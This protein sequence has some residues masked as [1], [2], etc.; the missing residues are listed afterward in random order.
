MLYGDCNQQY[1]EKNCYS[2]RFD[3]WINSS[4][5]R[6]KYGNY[7][8]TA[9]EWFHHKHRPSKVAEKDTQ[10]LDG[11]MDFSTCQSNYGINEC[12]V[13]YNGKWVD[14]KQC[15]SNVDGKVQSCI[16]QKWY[17]V[18]VNPN[19]PAPRKTMDLHTCGETYGYD[20]CFTKLRE[21]WVDVEQCR[22]SLGNYLC[23]GSGWYFF[24][25]HP[26][27][28]FV[29]DRSLDLHTCINAHGEDKCFVQLRGK[30]SNLTECRALIGNYACTGGG[31]YAFQYKPEEIIGQDGTMNSATCQDLFGSDH[32]F[33]KLN[34]EWKDIM[35]C[36]AQIGQYSC[37]GG[38]WTFFQQRPYKL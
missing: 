27:K 18:K 34:D 10:N 9:G 17:H 13:K 28:E 33:V 7:A 5:C 32:C 25:M 21:K 3:E 6:E 35:D 38:G 26:D 29:K 36:R 24:R 4:E 30:W 37:T 12:F 23:T 2:Y 14:A 20:R 16:F 19:A 22:A 8:C 11:P 15:M 31:W 1:G